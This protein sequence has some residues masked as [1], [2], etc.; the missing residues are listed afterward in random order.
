MT[1]IARPAERARAL[2]LGASAVM[3]KPLRALEVLGAV[4]T[5]LRAASRV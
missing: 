2:A 3:T 5:E 4:R 1:A